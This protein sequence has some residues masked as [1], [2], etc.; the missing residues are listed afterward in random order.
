[1]SG[2]GEERRR[3]SLLCSGAPLDALRLVV[4]TEIY[5]KSLSQGTSNTVLRP[6]SGSFLSPERKV[7]FI[8]LLTP[9]HSRKA[10]RTYDI[11]TEYLFQGEE[12]WL[13]WLQG[14]EGKCS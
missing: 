2:L 10:V 13:D 12:I 7:S 5:T 4:L 9:F 3:K 1:M 8:L 6:E 11:I 14:K